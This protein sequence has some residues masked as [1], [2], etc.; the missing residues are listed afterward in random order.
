[1]TTFIGSDVTCNSFALAVAPAMAATT[2][3]GSAL[4]Q[5]GP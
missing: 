5:F 3:S 4:L 1:M 2:A